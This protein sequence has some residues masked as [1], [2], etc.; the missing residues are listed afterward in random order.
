M[1]DV[2]IEVSW[3]AGAAAL[4]GGRPGGPE[5]VLDSSGA[6]GPSPPQLLAISLAGCMAIDVNDL[7]AKM[8]L[9]LE[10]LRVVVEGDRRAD[11]PRRFVALRQRFIASGIAAADEP[12]IRRAIDLSYEKYCSILHSLRDDIEMTFDLELV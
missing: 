9:P 10:S 1:A 3:S 11:P 4:R 7:A 12:K 5:V 8:R 6:E 2:D